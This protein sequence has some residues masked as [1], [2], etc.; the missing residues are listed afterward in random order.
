MTNKNFI[1][2]DLELNQ[3]SG[4]IIQV[5]CVVGNLETGE[6]LEEYSKCIKIDEIINDRIIKLTG[7]KQNDVDNGIKLYEAYIDLKNLHNK[8]EC[9][10][11]AITW[12]GGDCRALRNALNLD[13]EMFLFGRREIDAKT[14][15]VS[16]RFANNLKHQGGLAR[17]MGQLGLQFKGKKHCAV[18]DARNTFI[19]CRKLLEKL[20]GY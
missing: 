18:D 12:G 2:L 17:A 9:F 1:S 3:P 20:I 8:Y 14:L 5:G 4:T 6:I 13:D 15:Y 11:N 10:R 16:Y 7:I 19:V